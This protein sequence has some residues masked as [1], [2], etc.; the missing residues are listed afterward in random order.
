MSFGRLPVLGAYTR[1]PRYCLS[2][3]GKRLSDVNSR[4]FDERNV[5][6]DPQAPS[7]IRL[8][9]SE[10]PSLSVDKTP[11]SLL[12]VSRNPGHDS[13]IVGVFTELYALAHTIRRNDVLRGEEKRLSRRAG[14]EIPNEKCQ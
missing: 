1:L 5:R 2:T 3:L 11:A 10:L 9:V 7:R 14:M 12:K 4:D 6:K 8:D 13:A